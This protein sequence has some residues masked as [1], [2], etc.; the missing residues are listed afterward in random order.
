MRKPTPSDFWSAP[1][2]PAHPPAIPPVTH[3]ATDITLGVNSIVAHAA[4]VLSGAPA[5]SV[6][7]EAA[8][9]AWETR[10]ANEVK[11]GK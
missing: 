11:G 6:R 1:K 3:H 5:R 7:S 8:Y 9:K 10:R 4:A 2:P